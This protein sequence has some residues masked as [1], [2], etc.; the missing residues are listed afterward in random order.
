M[1]GGLRAVL[2]QNSIAHTLGCL[3]RPEP[4]THAGWGSLQGC[5]ISAE[6]CS[7]V[8]VR[9]QGSVHQ[10]RRV[11]NHHSSS[12]L[13]PTL[14]PI[15]QKEKKR[16]EN[17]SGQPIPGMTTDC[18]GTDFIKCMVQCNNNGQFLLIFDNCLYCFIYQE[19]DTGR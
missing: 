6:K 13:V 19:V 2:N 16:G 4:H 7:S 5:P 17:D 1:L 18:T 3:L 11:I 14:F 9:Q 10:R 15:W 8:R 12:R